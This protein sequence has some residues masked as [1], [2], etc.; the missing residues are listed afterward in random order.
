MTVLANRLVSDDWDS[1][2]ANRCLPSRRRAN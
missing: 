2:A 1:P